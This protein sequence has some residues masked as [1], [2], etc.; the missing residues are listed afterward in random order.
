MN[1]DPVHFRKHLSA[2]DTIF[3][4]LDG[5]LY[6]GHKPIAGAARAVGRLRALGKRVY[7]LSNNSSKSKRQYVERL[8]AFDIPAT[9]DEVILSTDSLVTYLQAQ[10]IGRVHVLGTRGLCDAVAHAGI[11]VV[12]RDP[13]YVVIGYDTEL[14]YAK[15]AAA[16][17]HINAGVPMLATHCDLFCPSEDGPLPDVGSFLEMLKAATGKSPEQIFGKPTPSMLAAIQARAPVDPARALM[18]GDRLYTDMRFARNIGAKSLLVLSGETRMDQLSATDF[19][20]D[21]VLD[22]VADMV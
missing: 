3:F 16:C 5:T 8:R 12:D 14:T 7:F 21:F 19:S 1:R 10:R 15:L 17:R 6:L 9:D 18:V 22:S 2:V 11:A 4:D 13:E 20:P